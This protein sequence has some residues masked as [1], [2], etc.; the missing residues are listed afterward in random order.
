MSS[1][2]VYLTVIAVTNQVS[3]LMVHDVDQSEAVFLTV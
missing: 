2:I 3:L 1:L